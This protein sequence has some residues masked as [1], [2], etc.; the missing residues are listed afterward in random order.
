[1]RREVGKETHKKERD[2]DVFF[3]DVTHD[4]FQRFVFSFLFFT[5]KN[6]K[7]NLF[8]ISDYKHHPEDV[9]AGILLGSVVAVFTIFSIIPNNF[10][11]T[12][13]KFER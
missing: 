11:N 8:R 4:T 1:M 6:Y 2:L 7:K 9:I 3:Y 10:L 13:Q 12:K 5:Q